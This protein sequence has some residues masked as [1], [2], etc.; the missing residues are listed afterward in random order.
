[1]PPYAKREISS[2]NLLNKY[3]I[4]NRFRSELRRVEEREEVRANGATNDFY[5]DQYLFNVWQKLH[6]EHWGEIYKGKQ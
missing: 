1:M 5:A 3:R 6:R 2:Q 4:S